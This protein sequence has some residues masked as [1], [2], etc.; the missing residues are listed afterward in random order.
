MSFCLKNKNNS[1]V[2]ISMA[3]NNSFVEFQIDF[4]T[5]IALRAVNGT[6]IFDIFVTLRINSVSESVNL[7]VVDAW[8][9]STNTLLLTA[10]KAY[11]P[12]T[13]RL[14]TAFRRD[15]YVNEFRKILRSERDRRTQTFL[16]LIWNTHTN[17]CVLDGIRMQF[18]R[19]HQNNVRVL[20]RQ[21]ERFE[22]RNEI[23]IKVELS[24]PASFER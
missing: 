6:S 14:T 4:R 9:M 8:W 1:F 11:F 5:L 10:R 24:S 7:T 19:A 20:S 22:G 12:K 3:K 21:R 13:D 18:I 2:P 15:E 17:T 16:N 23:Y